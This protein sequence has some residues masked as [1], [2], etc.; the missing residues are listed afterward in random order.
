MSTRDNER[1]M[2]ATAVEKGKGVPLPEF[3]KIQSLIFSQPKEDSRGG[4]ASGNQSKQAALLIEFLRGSKFGK[5]KFQEWLHAV[6]SVPRNDARA[7]EA[8]VRRVYGTDLA[9]LDKEFVAY[10]KKR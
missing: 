6:G 10:C 2:A 9:G 1:G 7:I 3:V 8:A 5:A 4:D